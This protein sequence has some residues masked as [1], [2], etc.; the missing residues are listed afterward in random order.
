MYYAWYD[1]AFAVMSDQAT[2]IGVSN[3]N[4]CSLVMERMG[5]SQSQQHIANFGSHGGS[6]RTMLFMEDLHTLLA[7][8][9][10]GTIIQYRYDPDKRTWAVEHSYGNAGISEIRSR[11]RLGHLAIFGGDTGSV[12]VIDTRARKL[13]GS[14]YKTGI[15]ITRSLIACAVADSQVLIS[16]TGQPKQYSD[17][18]TDALD[19]SELAKSCRVKIPE[20]TRACGDD[21]ASTDEDE[22]QKL[23]QADSTGNGLR[24]VSNAEASYS[25]LSAKLEHLVESLLACFL[26]EVKRVCQ[27]QKGKI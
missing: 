27:N 24:C 23:S 1:S 12:R 11:T 3:Q 21:T 16:V 10:K 25:R 26:E 15:K 22:R 20:P 18:L 17:K 19:A 9:S 14:P 2:V 6:I 8:D 7:G 13:L 5:E 4:H